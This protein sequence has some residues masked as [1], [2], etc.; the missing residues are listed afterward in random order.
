[1]TATR[2]FELEDGSS[3]LETFDFRSEFAFDDFAEWIAETLHVRPERPDTEGEMEPFSFEW[4]GSIYE[5]AYS[6][7]WGCFIK[8]APELN[9]QLRQMQA[10]LMS[11]VPG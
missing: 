11:D 7:E 1:M 9:D 4:R 5:G 6:E 8:A 2:I 3:V 10:V